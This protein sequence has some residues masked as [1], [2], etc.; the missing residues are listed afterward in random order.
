MLTPYANQATKE[1]ILCL[2]G[3]KGFCETL[4]KTDSYYRNKESADKYLEVAR[5]NLELALNE[6]C[7]GLDEDQLRGIIRFSKGITLNVVPKSSPSAEQEDFIVSRNTVEVL[8]KS[9][10]SDCAF[11]DLEGKEAKNCPIRKALLRSLIIP[12]GTGDCPYKG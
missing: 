3:S 9:A 12:E 8:L 5:N 2:S 6:I 11:C 4:L 7:K 10:T 1:T